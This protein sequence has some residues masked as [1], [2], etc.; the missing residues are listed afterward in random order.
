[1]AWLER[2]GSFQNLL[3]H[4]LVNKHLNILTTVSRNK[5]NQ[6]LEFGQLTKYYKR[7]IFLEKSYTKG[8]WE[9]IARP[10][11]KKSNL[12]ISLD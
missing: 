10:F 4:R 11:S 12:S 3:C 1:M 5:G 7:N 8:G 6:P 2:W 9:T